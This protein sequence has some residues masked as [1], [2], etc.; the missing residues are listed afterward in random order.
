MKTRKVD[1]KLF[2]QMVR[3]GMNCLRASEKE[4]NALNVFP[5]ADGDTG[6]NMLATLQN[7]VRCA[8]TT[9]DLREYLKALSSGMLLGARGN[10][11]VI[12]SQIFKGIYLELSKCSAAA[13]YDLRNSF[14]RGYKVAYESV[15]HPVEGTILTVARE[16]IEQTTRQVKRLADVESLLAEYLSFME[17]SLADT[18]RLLPVLAEMGVVDSGAKGYIAIIRGMADY[19]NGIIYPDEP[20]LAQ[21]LAGVSQSRPAPDLSLFN[22]DSPLEKGYCMEFILQLMR[23]PS[24]DQ[25]FKQSMFIQV[26]EKMGNSLVVVCDDMRVKVHIHTQKPAP[27]M[28]YAQRYGEFLTFKL[29]NMQLQ[30]NEY[31]RERDGAKAATAEAPALP[32]K[33]GKRVP[34]AVIA[35]VDGAGNR[36]IF[37]DLGCRQIIECGP[38]MN[39]STQELLSAIA[40]ANADEAVVLPGNANLLLVAE[41]AAGMAESTVHVLPARTIP[42]SYFALAMDMQDGADISRRVEQ[43]RESIAGIET[44]LIAVA[45][46]AF[47]HNGMTFREHQWVALYRDE[48][49]A[50]A[51]SAAE[52][53]RL[54][55]EKVEGIEDRETCILFRGAGA[56]AAEEAD[57]E[58]VI[59]S[60]YPLMECSFLDGGQQVYDWMIGLA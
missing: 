31:M 19:L 24:Y 17:I 2:E 9:A 13:T 37:Q 1:G 36:A 39:A 51:A 38:T 11:G 5:V 16:G 56:N 45:A 28:E 25:R 8:R 34:F 50:T 23:L 33:P 14:I 7:G 60:M 6:T 57:I 54:G 59:Q 41:Q 58:Q 42:E 12:L 48:P 4:L 47:E 18:P 10:S 55:I 32:A 53:I 40:A 52:A 26:L 29:E 22:S 30:H 20:Y 35:A 27:I 43:M 3:N 21:E 15:I 46:R 49:V 44:L